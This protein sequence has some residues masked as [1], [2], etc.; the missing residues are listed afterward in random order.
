MGRCYKHWAGSGRILV[1]GLVKK[2]GQGVVEILQD[3]VEMGHGASGILTTTQLVLE[4]LITWVAS[5]Q[6]NC[7][8]Q[9]VC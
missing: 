3:A 4:M 2:S 6:P 1:T 7:M 8:L 9:E 5:V